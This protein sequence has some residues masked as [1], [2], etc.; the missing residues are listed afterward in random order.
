[1]RSFIG[2][3]AGDEPYMTTAE[4][5]VFVRLRQAGSI[6][7]F[8]IASC[9][10]CGAEVSVGKR[11]CSA[12][13]MEWFME[14]SMVFEPV[15]QLQG[16]RIAV[17]TMDGCQR[18]GV[19]TKITYAAVNVDGREVKVPTAIGLDNEPGDELPWSR[20]KAIT[21]EG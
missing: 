21:A 20:L 12:W 7:F 17:E 16:K 8:R 1:M 13:C 5:S 15:E 9:R 14:A 4:R 10:G 19:L 6:T 2:F 3:K 11:F 18:R